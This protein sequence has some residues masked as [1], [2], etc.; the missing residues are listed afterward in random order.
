MKYALLAVLLIATQPARAAS[1][2]TGHAQ[3]LPFIDDDY[4]KALALARHEHRPLF[5]DA[6][7][8]WCHTCRSMRAFVF[9]DP[10]LLAQARRFVWLSID[11]EKVQN[12]AFLASHPV[13][14]WPTLMIINAES[15]QAVLRWP[16][17]TTASQ[18]LKLLD[19]GE[20]SVR[21]GGKSASSAIAVADRLAASGRPRDAADAYRA[22]LASVDADT[23]PRVVEAMV[24]ALLVARDKIACARSAAELAPGLQRGTSFVNVVAMGLDCATGTDD[25]AKRIR[26]TLIPLGLEGVRL[27]GLIA[28]DRSALYESLVE[29]YATDHE[30]DRRK[31]T[32]ARW[33]AFVR[34]EA[35]RAA[36]AEQRA[37]FDPHTVNAAT[38]LGQPLLALPALQASER[39]FPR[40]YNP[41]AR[42][43]LV[44]FRA[45]KL[46]DALAAIDRA[47]AKV[48][49][50]RS[51]ELY[52]LKA[53][54]QQAKA[55]AAGV[56]KTMDQAMSVAA[57][58]PAAQR[59]DDM[60]ERIKKQRAELAR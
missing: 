30:E 52:L 44:Y 13:S 41:P 1:G 49:G 20:H 31:E 11:T 47:L 29:A 34:G 33:F 45:G 22:A 26:E 56:Q 24:T 3:G 5:V 35:D 38:A 32:A 51:V 54:I 9:T 21:G 27:P 55:D 40:D 10:A 48:Y 7:A 42:M 18:L 8:P 57:S 58:L 6:W 15:E 2:S 16:G 36:T 43:A 39:D 17:S 4:S 53:R 46:D 12:A 19:D 59:R 14:V 50:P 37:V 60:I 28:D 23:R 25:I